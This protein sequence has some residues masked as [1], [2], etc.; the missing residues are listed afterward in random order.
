M[1]FYASHFNVPQ[2]ALFQRDQADAAEPWSMFW[3]D[4]TLLEW[5]NA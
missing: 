2:Y 4:L 1:T 3:Y 5:F